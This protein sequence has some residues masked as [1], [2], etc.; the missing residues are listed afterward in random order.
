MS[1]QDSF[2]GNIYIFIPCSY[3]H[4]ITLPESFA[5]SAEDPYCSFMT[6]MSARFQTEISSKVHAQL[7][8]HCLG[9]YDLLCSDDL[10]TADGKLCERGAIF[11]TLDQNTRLGVITLVLLHKNFAASHFLDRVSQ[12]D[13]HIRSPDGSRCSLKSVLRGFGITGFYQP[14]ACLTTRQDVAGEVMVYYLANETFNS[15]NMAAN[16]V[17][18]QLMA[19]GSE[20]LAQY[21]SSDIFAGKNSVVR[22]DRRDSAGLTAYPDLSSDATFL[23]ILEVLALK[24]ASVSRT[25]AR[26][27][28]ALDKTHLLELETMNRITSE[29]SG[30]MPFW[31]IHIFKYITA[32]NL[33][34][35]INQRFGIDA[36]FEKYFSNQN[37]LQHKI[38]IR[39]GIAQKSENRILYFIAIILFVFEVYPALY[40]V[41]SRIMEGQP[42]GM[43]EALSLL[44]SGVSTA[45]ILVI[46]ILVIRRRRADQA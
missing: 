32:Q 36:S 11:L 10:E 42:P 39:Q 24:A 2:S 6:T 22:I 7:E 21:D 30:T 40:K 3:L 29:F 25:N 44:G 5:E 14:R 28:E 35:Q 19:S 16:I 37:F 20:N 33:A 12:D 4:E 45:F 46:I 13:L 43:N 31:D 34:N 18:P 9:H 1:T 15:T 38:N 23:F 27:I 41:F 8:R 17:S 26:V